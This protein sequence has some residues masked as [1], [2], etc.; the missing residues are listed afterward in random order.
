MGSM[1]PF[2]TGGLGDVPRDWVDG[3]LQVVAS[4]RDALDSGASLREGPLER[5]LVSRC[6]SDACCSGGLCGCRLVRRG[7]SESTAFNRECFD[8]RK[9]LEYLGLYFTHMWYNGES[10]ANA[11]AWTRRRHPA[12]GRACLNDDMVGHEVAFV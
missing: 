11:V 1:E 12:R 4:E 7:W 8:G 5:C 9:M 3:V 2:S 6:G 10:I